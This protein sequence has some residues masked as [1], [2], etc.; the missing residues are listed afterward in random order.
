MSADSKGDDNSQDVRNKIHGKHP[1][2]DSF[3][4]FQPRRISSNK[5][6]SKAN[7]L[8]NVTP[9]W[10]DKPKPVGST[11]ELLGQRCPLKNPLGNEPHYQG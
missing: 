1:T 10:Q 9:G 4:A 8:L 2:P 7:S 3:A 11:V 5:E 6:C